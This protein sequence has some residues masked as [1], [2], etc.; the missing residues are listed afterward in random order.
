MVTSMGDLTGGKDPIK[1]ALLGASMSAAIRVTINGAA[2][3]RT[4]GSSP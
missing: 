1:T 2:V 4:G 3:E